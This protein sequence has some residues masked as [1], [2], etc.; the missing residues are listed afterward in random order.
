VQDAE[1]GDDKSVVT[2]LIVNYLPAALTQE[3]FRA[4]FASIGPVQSCKLIRDKSTGKHYAA[5][6]DI[7]AFISRT[8]MN[9]T[10]PYTVINNFTYPY[11]RNKFRIS[12][13]GNETRIR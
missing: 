10:Y 1:Y 2:N 13:Y 3:E 5:N 8:V 7:P 9:F 11:I 6:I 4:L 12:L